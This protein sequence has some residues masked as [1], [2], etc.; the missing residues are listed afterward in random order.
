[1]WFKRQL[2]PVIN[3]VSAKQVG[4]YMLELRFDDGMVKEVDFEPFL[5]RTRHPDIR[6]Y[7]HPEKFQEFR[8]EHGDL[9]WGD[10]DLSFPVSDLH[11]GE[12]DNR[13]GAVAAA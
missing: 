10:W 11:R 7:L 3:I 2:M 6:A 4:S 8:I 1:M 12:I 13:A 9:I 5:R